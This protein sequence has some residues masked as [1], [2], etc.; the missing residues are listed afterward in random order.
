MTLEQRLERLERQNRWMKR[1][2]ALG[3]AVAAAV[4]LSGQAKGKAW[5]HLEVSSLTLMDKDGM[6]GASLSLFGTGTPHLLLHDKNGK[7]RVWLGVN[8]DGSASLDLYDKDGKGRV[9]LVVLADGS[10]RLLLAG[11]DGKVRT[12]LS[13]GD[14]SSG[15]NVF[16][17]DEEAR[18]WLGVNGDGSAALDLYDKNVNKRAT[19]G[20]TTT[21][22]KRTGAETKTTAGTLTL[23]DAKG[24]VIWQAPR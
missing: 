21:V 15:L 22:D 6:A 3:L 19:L 4:L 5:Q 7:K 20:V 18:V 8:K 12:A 17:K 23:L 14:G 2:G 13:V 10:P 24:D 16:N 11:K 9:A 1:V